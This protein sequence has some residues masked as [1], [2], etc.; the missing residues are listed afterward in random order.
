LSLNPH[1]FNDERVRHPNADMTL[2]GV[3]ADADG[4]DAVRGRA[5]IEIGRW[6]FVG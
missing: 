6:K 3:A 2:D 4:V 5:K 1:P